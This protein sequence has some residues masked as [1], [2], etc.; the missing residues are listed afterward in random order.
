MKKLAALLSATFLLASCGT[1]ADVGNV[2]TTEQLGGNKEQAVTE[3]PSTAT[4]VFGDP[5][6]SLD[7]PIGWTYAVEGNNTIFKDENGAKAMTFYWNFE[8]EGGCMDCTVTQID[9]EERTLTKEGRVVQLHLFTEAYTE[10]PTE[11]TDGFI[12]LYSAAV[13]NISAY[14]A[15][16]FIDMTVVDAAT[17][18]KIFESIQ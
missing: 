11:A 14:N 8:G 2:A 5:T 10:A 9:K 15:K 6:F 3:L 17:V 12:N 18:K 13:A 16:I 4:Y 1:P 7:Y